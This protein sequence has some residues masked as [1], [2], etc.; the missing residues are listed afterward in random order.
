MIVAELEHVLSEDALNGHNQIRTAVPRLLGNKIV[1]IPAAQ[2]RNLLL[3]ASSFLF[4]ATQ[5]R[6]A[7]V[8][9]KSNILF[10]S[11]RVA[12]GQQETVKFYRF[13]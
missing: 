8:S 1:L 12:T 2:S 6:L 7:S 11:L 5:G 3:F 13:V 4:S 9:R 10:N